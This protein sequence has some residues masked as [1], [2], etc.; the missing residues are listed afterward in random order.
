MSESQPIEVVTELSSDTE[1]DTTLVARFNRK[2]VA[3][4]AGTAT[5]VVGALALFGAAMKRRGKEEFI[6]DVGRANG[7]VPDETL[8]S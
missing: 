4:I 7:D 5:A 6:D 3:K 8:E 1:K 2:K